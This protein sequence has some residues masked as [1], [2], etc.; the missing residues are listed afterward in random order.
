VRGTGRMRRL[1]NSI[2]ES[3]SARG[4]FSAAVHYCY[5]CSHP[6]KLQRPSRS[7]AHKHKREGRGGKTRREDAAVVK[8]SRALAAPSSTSHCYSFP[9]SSTSS[10]SSSPLLYLSSSLS[11]P[12]SLFLAPSPSKVYHGSSRAGLLN[13]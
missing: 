7:C 8:K 6:G 11:H 3:S 4:K 1:V 9:A 13:G 10:S 5:H 2:A 12:V